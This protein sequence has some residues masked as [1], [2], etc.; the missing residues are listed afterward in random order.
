[1][2]AGL[3]TI[4]DR[5][6]ERYWET[7][8]LT[9]FDDRTQ[10]RLKEP[11]LSVFTATDDTVNELEEAGFLVREGAGRREFLVRDTPPTPDSA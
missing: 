8:S 6:V 9:D 1:M 5:I 3:L 11:K 10:L 2:R 4:I 7:Y